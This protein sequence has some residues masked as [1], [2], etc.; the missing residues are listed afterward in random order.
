VE[1]LSRG[2]VLAWDKEGRLLVVPR[3]ESALVSG[4]DLVVLNAI[5]AGVGVVLRS[6]AKDPKRVEALAGITEDEEQE[7]YLDVRAAGVDIGL[8]D[9]RVRNAG[10]RSFMEAN[11][12]TSVADGNSLVNQ[13][14][15]VEFFA[16][17]LSGGRVADRMTQESVKE[18]G[19]GEKDIFNIPK[20]GVDC[21]RRHMVENFG[22]YFANLP[23]MAVYAEGLHGDA[24][25]WAEFQETLEIASRPSGASEELVE[26]ADLRTMVPILHYAESTLVNFDINRDGTLQANEIWAGFPRFK[27][28]IRRMGQGKAE[29]EA[30]Q[31]TIF[32]YLLTFGRPLSNT[33]LSKAGLLSWH[34][35]GRH[36]WSESASRLDVLKVIAS[37]NV[38]SRAGRVT[39]IE[40]FF[41]RLGSQALE[42]GFR[43][44]DEK[45]L[46]EAVELFG[47]P[48]DARADFSR[49]ASGRAKSIFASDLG[50]KLTSE[51]FIA[52]LSHELKADPRLARVCQPLM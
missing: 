52:N 10:A 17:I 24:K 22:S 26:N 13:H 42:R 4:R 25:K 21:F 35:A 16:L 31:K 38:F 9:P 36:V 32:S 14:E 19:V 37:L 23:G 40:D 11:I 8:L 50:L 30:I 12:F 33:W 20:L 43:S 28:F 34:V 7:F 39:K 49:L 15:G 18:C 1:L 45:I 41:N 44:G 51:K 2:R 27:E 48:P 47:C 46:G 5:R 6:Y 3:T 29:D